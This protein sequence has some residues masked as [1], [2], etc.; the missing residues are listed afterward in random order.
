MMKI[1][2]H[3]ATL[4]ILTVLLIA[5]I[6]TYLCYPL[7]NQAIQRSNYKTS[8]ISNYILLNLPQYCY[9]ADYLLKQKNDTSVTLNVYDPVSLPDSLKE[10]FYYDFQY[11]IEEKINE[12]NQNE[13][14]F[15]HIVNTQTKQE[16]SNTSHHIEDFNENKALQ[17]QYQWY[18]QV[19]FDEN[20][21]PTLLNISDQNQ[22][23]QS[24]IPQFSYQITLFDQNSGENIT[25]HCQPLKNITIT[26][27][28]SQQLHLTSDIGT[29]LFNTSRSQF[30]LYS[31][32]YIFIAVALC[33]ITTLFIPMKH[34]KKSRF[35]SFI[36]QIKFGFLAIIW[37][38]MTICM[39]LGS[40][41]MI[42]GTI[43][44]QF[45]YIYQKFGIEYLD[46]YITP[47]INIIYFFI[48]YLLFVILA[49]FIKYLFHKG[50]KAYFKE[51][52][53]LGW[54][55]T[56]GYSLMNKVINFDFD[57]SINKVVLKI[58]LFNLLIIAGCSIFFVF[59]IFF[60]FIYSII[61]FI[62]IKKKFIDIQKDYQTLLQATKQLSQGHFD[63]QI[64]QDIGI[65]NPLKDEFVHI[66]D[67]FEKAVE[68]EVKSQK[69]KTEL[70]SN[71]SHDLKT[72]LTSIITYI[73][74]LKNKDISTDNQKHYLDIL[75][76][77]AFRLKNLIEDLFEVSKAN[78]GDVQLELVDID[79]ISLI[80]QAQLECQDKLDEKSLVIKWNVTNEKLICHLDSSKTYRI[81]EN[82]F[83]NICKYAMDNTRVFIEMIEQ[84]N[85]I[86]IIFKNISQDEM[87]FNENEIVERFVQGDKSRN[88]HGSG[89]GLAIVKSF[90]EL[91][92]GQFYIEL[93]GDLFKSIIIFPK[94]KSM[95]L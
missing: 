14:I 43:Q 42:A 21:N 82:L 83:M 90:T 92:G 66:K 34:L 88:S 15:Y 51:N 18:L 67:G 69:M 31:F 63:I 16:L 49:Y 20:G 13:D 61:I 71:V 91:Q 62:L 36:M 85:H 89:L 50:F 17:K 81:F 41:I 55:L 64:N 76:R 47:F 6:G 80:K 52:T 57:D 27:A 5:S 3:I 75:E 53:C 78:S 44:N 79:I 56:N 2:Q 23:N 26:L 9:S 24:L 25:V 94:Q 68:K 70:I 28:V 35:L 22:K 38:F 8:D 59:G 65:F 7:I 73:D 11:P 95:G 77:N 93:D 86:Q 10:E 40:A 54:I 1:K 72:P 46:M 4:I 19:Q 29:H 39:Y 60:A 58:V 37:G 87:T 74:L 45:H 33:G 30:Y 84:D 32:P 12:L 48:F